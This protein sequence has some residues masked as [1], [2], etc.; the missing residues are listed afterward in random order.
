MLYYFAIVTKDWRTYFYPCIVKTLQTNIGE[1]LDSKERE[2]R[3]LINAM[4]TNMNLINTL[5]EL[6]CCKELSFG[7]DGVFW[8]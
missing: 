7:R 2:G 8:G 1:S 3:N 6:K 5:Q 4:G